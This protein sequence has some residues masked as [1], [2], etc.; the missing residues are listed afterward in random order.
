M[1]WW[2]LG[3]QPLSESTGR[4][5]LPSQAPLSDPNRPPID[6]TVNYLLNAGIGPIVWWLEN[7]QPCSP[8]QMAI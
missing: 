6:L 3:A 1:F 8:E 4:T 5:K 7:D 2:L